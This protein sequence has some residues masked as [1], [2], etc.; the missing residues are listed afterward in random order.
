MFLA[1]REEIILK[2]IKNKKVLDLGNSWGDLKQLI[3]INCK[4]YKGLD[5]EGKTDFKQDLNQLFDLK[6]KFDVIIAGELIEHIENSGIF[7][8]NIS[9]HLTKD[10]TFFLSTPNAT[11]FRFMFYDLFNKEPAYEGHIK[12]FTKDSLI[13]ILKSHFKV[14]KVGFCN[15]TTNIENKNL[16]WKVKFNIE[17]FIGMIISR[18]SPNL[19]AICKKK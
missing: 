4:E 7:L 17:N 12:Y 13:L 3:K 15:L 2:L 11:S 6:E 14:K 18:Y 8:Q 19:Y 9:N 10:G 5:I 1:T 16:V